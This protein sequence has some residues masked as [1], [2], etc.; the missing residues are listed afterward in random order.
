MFA[1]LASASAVWPIAAD[2]DHRLDPTQ[3]PGAAGGRLRIGR[4][5]LECASEG[6]GL[7]EGLEGVRLWR[8]EEEVFVVWLVS[9]LDEELDLVRVPPET[10]GGAVRLEVAQFPAAVKNG[11]PLL[12]EH[13]GVSPPG[14]VWV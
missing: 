11:G 10:D 4:A 14:I 7:M 2:D 8:V 3:P 12:H 9:D 1:L 6:E 5:G 13:S